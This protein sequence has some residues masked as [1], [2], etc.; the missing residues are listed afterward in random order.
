MNSYTLLFHHCSIFYFL[1]FLLLSLDMHM[2]SIK[3]LLRPP[4]CRSY[5]FY[6]LI[7][8][9]QTLSD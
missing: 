8:S 4:P 6:F 7:F 3:V 5:G 9:F 1:I 2:D